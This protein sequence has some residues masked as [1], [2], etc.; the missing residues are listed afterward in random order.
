MFWIKTNRAKTNVKSNVP[1]IP[2][3]KRIIDKYERLDN[4]KLLPKISN[5]KINEYLKEIATLCRIDKKLTHYT[6]RH[7]FAT[8]VTLG[9]GIAIENVS[10]MMG[11]TTIKMTQHYAKVLDKNVKEDMNKLMQKFS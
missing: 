6:A 7:T 10:K 4:D 3:A 8:T 2:P 11:H 1:L 5:Q 9:N